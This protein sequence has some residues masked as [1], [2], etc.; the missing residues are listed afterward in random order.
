MKI[1]IENE[2][3]FVKFL[4]E[5]AEEVVINEDHIKLVASNTIVLG[6]NS[7]NV[8]VVE[9][10]TPPADFAGNKYKYIN[11]EFELLPDWKKILGIKEEE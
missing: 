7:S 5:D 3:S 4:F 6:L 11:G 9:G 1:I 8:T 10:I 2:T